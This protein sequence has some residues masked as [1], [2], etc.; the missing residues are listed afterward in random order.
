M[1]TIELYVNYG[2][3][4]AEYQHIYTYGNPHM[5]AKVSE[6]IEVVIPSTWELSENQ[7][8]ELLITAPWGT[9]YRPH[10]LLKSIDNEPYFQGCDKNGDF[11]T[12]KLVE[13]NE[14]LK[15]KA[16]NKICGLLHKRKEKGLTQKELSERSGINIRQIQKYESLSSEPGNMTLKNAIALADT[17]GCDVRELL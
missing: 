7:F 10:E 9:A 16:D 3:L 17:L 2:V 13:I 6:K 8:G 15:K 4:S 1:K 14:Y 12:V 5:Q 11:F